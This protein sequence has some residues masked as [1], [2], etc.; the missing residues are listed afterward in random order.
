M[1]LGALLTHS[2]PR[3]DGTGTA[4][5]RGSDRSEPLPFNRETTY[6]SLQQTTD[7]QHARIFYPLHPLAG[8]TLWIRERRRGPPATYL[9][10]AEDGEV[11]SVP[12]W[13]TEPAAADLR[14]GGRPQVH[15]RALLE[16]FGLM[17]KGLESD[18]TDGI[19]PSD[20]AKETPLEDRTTPTVVD[21]ESTSS[22]PAPT[23]RSADPK[24]RAHRKDAGAARSP[25]SK[26]SR[27]SGGEQ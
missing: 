9:L 14:D 6:A 15:V 26:L 24:R 11:F 23:S 19:L 3:C 12:V 20:Q 8:R 4:Q 25:K 18:G 22:C 5:E 16:I 27:V 13:M 10:A 21:T 7:S 1:E 17:R 2:E